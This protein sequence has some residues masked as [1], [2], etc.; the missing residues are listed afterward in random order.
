MREKG[1][2]AFYAHPFGREILGSYFEV[3]QN[4]GHDTNVAHIRK[5]FNR[6]HDL[7]KGPLNIT[8]DVYERADGRTIEHINAKCF[9]CDRQH[10]CANEISFSDSFE[11]EFVGSHCLNLAKA[12]FA[13]LE[14]LRS[15]ARELVVNG[16]LDENL[17]YIHKH[18]H[19]LLKNIY[20]AHQNK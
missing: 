4:W 2:H 18:L 20:I 5:I 9:F 17:V 11:F 14:Y 12:V 13:F 3:L 6:F 7:L 16:L 8:F 15:S 19:F 10:P 1:I